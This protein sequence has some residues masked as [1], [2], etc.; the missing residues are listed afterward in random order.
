[1]TEKEQLKVIRKYAI[2]R[3]KFS[4]ADIAKKLGISSAKA[5]GLLKKVR[6]AGV[7]HG[8]P[9]DVTSF[10]T[11]SPGY[12]TAA[13]W[14]MDPKERYKE[15]KKMKES[16]LREVIREEILNELEV[17]N[18]ELYK[19]VEKTVNEL[20]T[21]RNKSINNISFM[22][23]DY[24]SSK[25]RAITDRAKVAMGHAG[26]AAKALEGVETILRQAGMPGET[27]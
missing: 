17:K 20:H 4:T 22:A 10:K 9:V 7:I 2:Q 12:K 23:N 5:V 14:F 21:I 1:M 18:T 11:G 8:G 26:N 6:A 27:K 3:S 24:E 13:Q 16:E 15:I 19:L 25:R